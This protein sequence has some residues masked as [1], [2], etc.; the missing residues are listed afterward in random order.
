MRVAENLTLS[1][2]RVLQAALE[3]IDETG[4]SKFTIKRLADEL[5]VYPTAVSWHV[6]TKDELL[7]DLSAFIFEG[8]KLPG[9]TD[10]GWSE[11]L[12]DTA[13]VVRRQMHDHPNLVPII[14]SRLSPVLPSLPFVERVLRILTKA[15]LQGPL[16]LQAYNTYV[17]TLLG[18]VSI[19]LSRASVAQEK[20]R[21][22]Y[23]NA[24]DELDTNLYT[25]VAS[26]REL[27]SN[28]A[29]MVRW[30]N[31]A[32]NAMDES[33]EFMLTAIIDGIRIHTGEI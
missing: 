22:N 17:G 12:R 29:F 15:G 8:V 3:L 30:S 5:G 4:L 7:T 14:G 28:Q 23:E 21:V 19:E 9:D 16:L 26:N 11:W 31:G 32:D 1:K 6:G 18:W 2:K 20:A 10:K 27:I 13:R 25:S 24:L 33:F